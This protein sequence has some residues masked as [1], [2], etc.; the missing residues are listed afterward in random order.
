MNS[1]DIARMIIE[2]G[3]GK[4][5]EVSG[6]L[7]DGSGFM[8]GSFP[9]PKNHWLIADPDGFNIPP[10]PMRMGWNHPERKKME[11]N[12][13]L[14]GKYA[15]RS[16]TMNGKDLDFSPDA[17]LQNLIVGML[18]YWTETGLSSDEFANPKIEENQ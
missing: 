17:L 15:C 2:E 3:G 1:A 16:A 18:G 7:P 11:E 10:M 6:P 4:V 13:R 14:A 8:V 9:L 12:L 5:E